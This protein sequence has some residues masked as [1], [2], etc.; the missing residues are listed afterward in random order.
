MKHTL[1]EDEST[2]LAALY[3]LGA[4]GRQEAHDFE[5][6]L[7]EGCE[8][9]AEELREF[10]EVVE[11]LARATVSQSPP[12][13]VHEKLLARIAHEPHPSSATR[14]DAETRTDERETAPLAPLTV[15]SR[16]HA[17]SSQ[18]ALTGHGRGLLV[19][20]AD[21]G[22]WR[23]TPDPGVFIKVLY[24]DEERATVT[25]LLRMEPGSRIPMHPQSGT[26]QCLVLEG[27][28]RAGDLTLRAGDYHCALPNTHHDELTTAQGNL[29]L[30][31]APENHI[32]I[33]TRSR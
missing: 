15:P 33:K 9:C 18:S 28:L 7:A 11:H 10:Q 13:E 30:V 19:V 2:E 29:L 6:H 21:E 25:S 14:N 27:D 12:R 26:E 32:L 4:L 5:N 1:A 31:F 8:P 20:R 16:E 3:A 22:T 24:V 23:P 17:A